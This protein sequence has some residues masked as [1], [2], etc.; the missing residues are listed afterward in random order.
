MARTLPSTSRNTSAPVPQ[1]VANSGMCQGRSQGFAQCDFR[2]YQVD[3]EWQQQTCHSLGLEYC[4]PNRFAAGSCTTALTRPNFQTVRCI[5]GDWNCLFRSFSMII[6][7]S[8]EHHLALCI[9]ILQHMQSIAH[10]LLGAHVK[11]TSIDSYIHETSM[12]IVR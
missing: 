10:L 1:S 9:A 12:D 11:Q 3:S 4:R 8:Q 5:T 6:T 7:G 2:F